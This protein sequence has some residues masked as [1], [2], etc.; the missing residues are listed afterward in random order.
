MTHPLNRGHNVSFRSVW[1][2]C[3]CDPLANGSHVIIGHGHGP[4]R[5]RGAPSSGV[6]RHL[7]DPAALDP[8]VDVAIT[9]LGKRA[10]NCEVGVALALV[11]IYSNR[12]PTAFFPNFA[13]CTNIFPAIRSTFF[14]RKGVA[15]RSLRR[16]PPSL[17]WLPCPTSGR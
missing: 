13:A 3:A 2:G 1:S 9:V 10:E 6:T 12:R 4:G 5:L 17:G 14:L 16:G 8:H 7:L 11:R 15:M